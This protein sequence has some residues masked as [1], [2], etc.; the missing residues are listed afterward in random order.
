MEWLAYSYFHFGEHK[1]AYD[2]YKELLRK[3]ETGEKT[4]IAAVTKRPMSIC[5]TRVSVDTTKDDFEY[6]VRNM[7]PTANVQCV[8]LDTRYPSYKSFKVNVMTEDTNKLLDPDEWPQGIL[9][10]KFFTPRQS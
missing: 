6:H 5:I 7:L 10:R 1:K 2:V 4:N 8:L 9:V 3:P